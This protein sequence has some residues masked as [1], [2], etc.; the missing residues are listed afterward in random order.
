MKEQKVVQ[1]NKFIKDSDY[2]IK[3][4]KQRGLVYIFK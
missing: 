4:D 1:G 3:Y 2:F